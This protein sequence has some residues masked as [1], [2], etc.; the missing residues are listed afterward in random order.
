MAGIYLGKNA[1]VTKDILPA[2]INQA[3]AILRL[4]Q[5]VANPNYVSLYLSQQSMIDFVNNMSGQSAQPNLN[6]EEIKSIDI[7]LPPLPGQ[8]H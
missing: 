6:F 1:I 2:N 8:T 4:N 5:K 3:L 7:S